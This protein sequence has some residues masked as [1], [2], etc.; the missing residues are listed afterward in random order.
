MKLE[1]DIKDLRRIAAIAT[2]AGTDDAR[3][4]L[5]AILLEAGEEGHLVAVAT[6]SYR[7]AWT[8]LEHVT[9]DDFAPVLIN[10]KDYSRALKGLGKSTPLAVLAVEGAGFILSHG[11]YVAG[12][13]TVDGTFPQWR[14][15]IA[16]LE[17]PGD[18]GAGVSYNARYLAGPWEIAKALGCGTRESVRVDVQ[19]HDVKPGI[20]VVMHEWHPIHYLLMPVK[21][22]S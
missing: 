19:P 17:G 5:T 3:P 22:T 18:L 1:L 11:S 6:D 16:G 10:A 7:L 2:A 15:L 12:G 21:P 14:M 4:V 20:F 13:E 8:Q 9:P